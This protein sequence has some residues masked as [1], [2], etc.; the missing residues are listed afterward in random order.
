[1]AQPLKTEEVLRRVELALKAVDGMRN[2]DLLW[3][4]SAHT[5]GAKAHRMI[6][7]AKSDRYSIGPPT[8]PAP[9]WE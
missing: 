8:T 2:K 5:K 6:E 4:T 9:E 1:M 7:I 3:I